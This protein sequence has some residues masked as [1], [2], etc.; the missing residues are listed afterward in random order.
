MPLKSGEKE[1]W[2]S[3]SPAADFLFSIDPGILNSTVHTDTIE[4]CNVLGSQT[5]PPKDTSAQKLDTLAQTLWPK[6]LDTSAQNF[7]TL[8]PKTFRPITI[9]SKLKVHLLYM[10][11][12][13]STIKETNLHGQIAWFIFRL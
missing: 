13:N 4:T 10:Y 3:G 6:I 9:F 11:T 2:S 12:V 5:F 1:F 7:Q 8:R